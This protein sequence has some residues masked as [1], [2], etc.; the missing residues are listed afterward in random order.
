MRI[1]LSIQSAIGDETIIVR[2]KVSPSTC[3]GTQSPLYFYSSNNNARSVIFA[4]RSP[5]SLFLHP[6]DCCGLC[7]CKWDWSSTVGGMELDSDWEAVFLNLSTSSQC[8]SAS[9]QYL[10]NSSQYLSNSSQYL[11]NSSQYLS[12]SF[13]YLSNSSQ[14]LSNSF[15]YLSN[16]SQYLSNSSQYLFN[17][18][19]YLS[20][21]FQY[22]TTSP[23]WVLKSL[24]E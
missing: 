24:D 19:Q 22:L 12:N 18:S 17:S 2:N 9:S 16:P 14:Y 6:M 10:S 3:L 15:Q 4:N 21:S 11:S 23:E 1:K 13:Q 7:A 20:N 5:C 8:L